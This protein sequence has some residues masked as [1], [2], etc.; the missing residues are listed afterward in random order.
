MY[1]YDFLK[2]IEPLR[3]SS[4]PPEI[5]PEVTKPDNREIVVSPY[6]DRSLAEKYISDLPESGEYFQLFFS[7][8]SPDKIAFRDVTAHVNYLNRLKLK[9][10]IIPAPRDT[11]TPFFS[12]AEQSCYEA[13]YL[14]DCLVSDLSDY[15]VN[16][17][18]KLGDI[19]SEDNVDF[20][21]QPI[22]AK[23]GNNPLNFEIC[24]AQIIYFFAKYVSCKAVGEQ[25]TKSVSEDAFLE[26]MENG[27][28]E[29]QEKGKD[30][31]C[32]DNILSDNQEL[33]SFLSQITVINGDA[34][35]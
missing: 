34:L 30:S 11:V 5:S 23:F 1:L 26:I 7:L 16:T 33:Y 31:D 8:S 18:A 32:F 14:F 28:D 4:V 29:Y 3:K 10:I 21:S 17:N 22:L 35:K 13:A 2:E 27:I 19:F 25:M 6:C 12:G 9:S 20:K 15:G 24:K